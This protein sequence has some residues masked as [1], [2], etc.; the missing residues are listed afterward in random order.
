LSGFTE[1]AI[2]HAGRL[3]E[4]VS[5]LSKP[6]RKADLAQIIRRALARLA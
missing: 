4:G 3:E 1:T 5:L 6:F 2:L